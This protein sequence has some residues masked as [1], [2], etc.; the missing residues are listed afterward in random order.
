MYTNIQ[1]TVI[2][3]DYFSS[4]FK[5]CRGVRQ[6]FPISA[7]LF[8]LIVEILAICIRTNKKIHGI[9]A[10]GKEIKISQL[11]DD[12]TL[13]LKDHQ[14]IPEILKV[15]KQCHTLSGLHTNIDK[16]QAFIIG[17][18]IRFK[19]TYNM[20]W[21]TGPIKLL[22]I[23]ICDS[24][25]EN[26]NQNFEPKI[27]QMKSLFNI[28][29]QRRL[30]LKGKITIIN[31][32]AASLLVYPCTCLETPAKVLT[33][34]NKL[35]LD[36]LWDNGSSKIAKYTVIRQINEGGLK[37]INLE[38]KLSSLKLTWIKRSLMNPNCT[39]NLILTEIL[40]KI[41]FD[42]ILKCRFNCIQ[43]LK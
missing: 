39:W 42:Y 20:K 22:G 18:H 31:S 26:Y 3:N 7:Y 14:S 12:T 25:N 10:N 36:F 6:G 4:Y 27:K 23:S 1:S 16:T 19:E 32:L 5:I 41:P 28:W 8:L 11:A 38:S 34:V 43:Y 35:F 29:K 24:E 2:N 9:I 33:Q 17:K 21:D 37:L 40:N 13:I 30:S 15:L